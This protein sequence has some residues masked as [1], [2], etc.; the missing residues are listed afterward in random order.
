MII[1]LTGKNAAGKGEVAAYLNAKGFAYFS[2]SDELRE[3]AKRAG[4][5]QSREN[6]IELGN[7]L[8][9]KFGAGYLAKKI[10][11]KIKSSGAKNSVIDSIRNLE[12]IAELRKNRNF[13]LVAVDA[14]IELRFQRAMQRKRAGEANSLEEFRMLEERENFK[15][16][17]GQQLNECVKSADEM[18]VNDGSLEQLHKKVDEL[19]EQIQ[20]KQ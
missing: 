16:K 9:E 12:E 8:R 3:E 6:L 7:S 11:A 10:N 13:V 20:A 19:L 4:I 14:P 18:I 2:L 5:E 17:T 15:N 1:G